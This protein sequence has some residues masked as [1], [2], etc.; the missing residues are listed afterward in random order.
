MHPQQAAHRAHVCPGELRVH[1]E[2]RGGSTS[3]SWQALPSFS[4]NLA[5]EPRCSW[6]AWPAGSTILPRGPRSAGSCRHLH[7]ELNPGGVVSHPLCKEAQGQVAGRPGDAADRPPPPTRRGVQRSLY[8]EGRQSAG[9]GG[10][11]C[12]PCP[13]PPHGFPPC[14]LSSIALMTTSPSQHLSLVPHWPPTGARLLA[15]RWRS[16]PR[17]Q[18]PA[19]GGQ[20]P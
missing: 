19:P 7:G 2:P 12:R 16:A 14:S 13:A 5:G 4:A 11:L 1:A 15:W 8:S 10:D 18:C 9:P 6:G 3:H 17:S 20:G